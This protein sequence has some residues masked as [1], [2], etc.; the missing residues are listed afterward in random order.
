MKFFTYK[1]KK[2]FRD[3]KQLRMS[4]ITEIRIKEIETAISFYI[5][6]GLSQD[7]TCEKVASNFDISSEDVKK[8]A[9]RNYE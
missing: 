8:I 1:R 2:A 5:K 6:N 3:K 4:K 7:E 9:E